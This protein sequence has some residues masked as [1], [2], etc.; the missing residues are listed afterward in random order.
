MNTYHFILTT[1]QQNFTTISMLI[2]QLAISSATTGNYHL[3]QDL[4][5]YTE[6]AWYKIYQ[7][8]TDHSMLASVGI[9]RDGFAKLL[10]RFER[11]YIVQ[12]GPGLPGRPARLP[13][14]HAVLAMVLTFYCDTM[15]QKRIVELF[16]I[17]RS[18]QSRILRKAEVALFQVLRDEREARIAWPTAAEQVLWSTR[19][20]EREPL[21][22]KK[23]GFMDGKNF[24][25]Q[26][27][28]SDDLQNAF[29]NGWLHSTLITG[30]LCFGANGC[31]VWMCHNNPGSWNDGETSR[32]FV[33]NLLNTTKCPDQQMGVLTDSA[34]SVSGP[35]FG[36]IETPLKTGDFERIPRALQTA[37]LAKSNAICSIRQAAE[38]G[39]GAS[40][41]VFGRLKMPLPFNPNLRALRLYNIHK[42][43]NFR[44]RTTGISQIRTVFMTY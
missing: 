3:V 22:Q 17:P 25:V 27:P 11:V 30:V 23:W 28:G 19:I 13:L 4:V 44:V 39:M 15:S 31:I 18:T 37:A 6:T 40:E 16:G 1:Q 10:E 32:G 12:S 42:L 8:P 5:S 43:Y 14:K 29:Y 36:R 7:N 21:I 38:W 24:K 20:S 35:L 34:F 2:L 41:K 9:K 33:E 26:K